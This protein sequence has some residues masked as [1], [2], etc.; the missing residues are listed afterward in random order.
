MS[1]TTFCIL[2]IGGILSRSDVERL[3]DELRDADAN[4][5]D[6]RTFLDQ[7]SAQFSF[8]AAADGDLRP[9][10]RATLDDL[11]LSYVWRWN[12]GLHFGSGIL[13]HDARDE[14]QDIFG[15]IDGDLALN[16][17]EI[18]NPAR[19]AAARHFKAFQAQMKLLTYASNHE[20]ATLSAQHPWTRDYIEKRNTAA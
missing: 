3:A 12:A 8:H 5:H 17:D 16:L 4:S 11:C 2:Q 6:I 7:E 18:D 9:A 20:L 13:F 1:D 15:A 19:L 10:L 14:S